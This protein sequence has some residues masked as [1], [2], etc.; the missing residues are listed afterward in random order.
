VVGFGAAAKGITAIT[1]FEIS[2]LFEYIVDESPLKQ[3]K[4]TPNTNI[5]IKPLSALS[6]DT[7]KLA[8]VILAW[9]FSDEILKKIKSIRTT[10][11]LAIVYFPKQ[12]C[13]IIM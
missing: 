10:E 7:R 5:P 9:N 4:F 12:T 2:H 8:I 6:S 13:E 3:G 11:S 1:F